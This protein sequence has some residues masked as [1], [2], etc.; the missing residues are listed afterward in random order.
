MR[1]AVCL[2]A[3]LLIPTLGVILGAFLSAERI[4]PP[5]RVGIEHMRGTIHARLLNLSRANN[6]QLAA[7]GL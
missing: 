1:I 2:M 7:V 4:E 6:P 3:L 5:V